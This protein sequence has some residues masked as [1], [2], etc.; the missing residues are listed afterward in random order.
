M[1]RASLCFCTGVP[2][3]HLAVGRCPRGASSLECQKTWEGP[4]N[5]LRMGMLFCICLLQR[6]P[7]VSL[8]RRTRIPR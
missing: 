8:R 7:G 2:E 5:A 3:P 6:P 1:P 4:S